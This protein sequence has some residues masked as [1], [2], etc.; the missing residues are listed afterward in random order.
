MSHAGWQCSGREKRNG[1]KGAT[2]QG[3]GIQ[4]QTI[5]GGGGPLFY[6]S[7]GRERG[8]EG[9]GEGRPWQSQLQREGRGRVEGGGGPGGIASSQSTKMERRLRLARQPRVAASASGGERERE[10]RY[11][12][13]G[14]LLRLT[15]N[16][17]RRS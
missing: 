11:N 12:N 15:V 4:S 8:T 9:E 6:L 17:H 7:I 5:T 14:K 16:F 2:V 1:R 3:C 10:R 13:F